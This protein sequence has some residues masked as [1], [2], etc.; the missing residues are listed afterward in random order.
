MRVSGPAAGH[1]PQ[2]LGRPDRHARSRHAQQLRGGN[3]PW[4]TYVTAEENFNATIRRPPREHARGG[5]LSP[6]RRRA[7]GTYGLGAPFDRFDLDKEPNEPNRFGWIVEIDPYDPDGVPVKRT[8]L[9]RF[10]H[11]AR[12]CGRQ[13][14][15]RG[16]LQ[17]DDER[18]EYVYKFVTA[19]A[20]NPTTAPPTATC[21]RRHALRRQFADDG[22]LHGCR[23]CTARGR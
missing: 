4:G 20:W 19:R 8:A 12:Q 18:F 13:G 23:W 17:G 14:R 1:A 2:D 15:P 10:K 16:V 22:K 9:G 11:E 3:T 7:R 6:L 5:G 21:G